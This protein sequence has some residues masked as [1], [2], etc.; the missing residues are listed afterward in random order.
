[1]VPVT[2]YMFI[3]AALIALGVYG[4]VSKRNFIRMLIS[5][6]IILNA[7][8]LNLIALTTYGLYPRVGPPD[9]SGHVMAMFIIGVAAAEA[10]VG[11]ALAVSVYRTYRTINVR[12]IRKL[13]G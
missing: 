2:Y 9:L 12:E 8:N 13:R 1:M 3:S 7:A 10:A 6:E 5:I 4:L 11:L